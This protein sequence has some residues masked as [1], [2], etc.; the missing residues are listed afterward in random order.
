MSQRFYENTNIG[1]CVNE[2]HQLTFSEVRS[3]QKLRACAALITA[4][5]DVSEAV[6]VTNEDHRIMVSCLALLMM[7]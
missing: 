3:Q 5:D 2:L 1:A 7:N 4:L 6:E